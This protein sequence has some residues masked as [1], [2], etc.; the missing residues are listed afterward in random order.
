MG[1]KQE[2]IGTFYELFHLINKLPNTHINGLPFVTVKLICMNFLFSTN[3]STLLIL[4]LEC[5]V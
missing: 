4:L 2:Q 3:C 5:I 1:E